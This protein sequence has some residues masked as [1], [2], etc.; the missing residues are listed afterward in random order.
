[1][2]PRTE[3][4]RITEA[5]QR[6]FSQIDA[7]QRTIALRLKTA[8]RLRQAVLQSAFSGSLVPQDPNDEPASVLLERIRTERAKQT[9]NEKKPGINGT[10]STRG[11]RRRWAG[12]PKIEQASKA[13][14]TEKA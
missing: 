5:V 4:A 13:A 8:Q 14:S 9:A 12:K 11:Q 6:Q 2:P 1:M 3:Q 10:P 7:S